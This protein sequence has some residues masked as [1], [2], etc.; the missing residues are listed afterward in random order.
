LT[1][2]WA[3]LAGTP[4]TLARP[5]TLQELHQF[6]VQKRVPIDDA[7]VRER[8][9]QI[10][11]DDLVVVALDAQN[12]EV[13]WQHVK[14]PRIVRSEEPGPDGLLSG[15]VFHRTDAELV[16]RVPDDIVPVTLSIYEPRWN[17]SD[18]TLRPVGTILLR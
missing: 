8:D 3:V 2:A 1:I 4:G 6:Q 14:D 18:F 16:L 11:A 15:Q 12:R 10:A 17:G 5:G 13:A 9:P 7:P